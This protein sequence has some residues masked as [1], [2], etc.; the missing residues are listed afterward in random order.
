MGLA[1]SPQGMGECENTVDTEV[2]SGH[3]K[4]SSGEEERRP[5]QSHS[6]HVDIMH[7]PIHALPTQPFIGSVSGMQLVLTARES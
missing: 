7:L 3:Y 2:L 6:N 1:Q 4:Q 5:P